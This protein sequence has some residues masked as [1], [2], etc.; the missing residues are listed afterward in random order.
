M[1]VQTDSKK[2]GLCGRGGGENCSASAVAAES[3][4]LTFTRVKRS[5]KQSKSKRGGPSVGGQDKTQGVKCSICIPVGNCRNSGRW[6]P[7]LFSGMG[8]FGEFLHRA[9]LSQVKKSAWHLFRIQLF[10]VCIS[11]TSLLC[12]KRT[13]NKF[14]SLQDVNRCIHPDASLL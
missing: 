7:L 8:S 6:L 5:G 9:I 2:R 12:I 13:T 1:P 4:R 10:S 11:V 14:V 3:C